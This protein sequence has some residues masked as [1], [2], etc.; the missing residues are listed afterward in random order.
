[1]LADS[2]ETLRKDNLQ[3]GWKKVWP[4]EEEGEEN[5]MGM[6]VRKKMCWMKLQRYAVNT[7]L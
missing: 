5:P 2:W 4:V 6:S 1:M 3:K 7:W